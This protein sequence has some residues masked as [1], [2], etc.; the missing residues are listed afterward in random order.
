MADED[1]PRQLEF[2]SFLYLPEATDLVILTNNQ[3]LQDSQK[4]LL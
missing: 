2:E 4:C 3:S 1:S